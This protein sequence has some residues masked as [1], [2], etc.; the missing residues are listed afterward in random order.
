MK[1]RTLF[2]I[3]AIC[4][5]VPALNISAKDNEALPFIRIVRD[6]AAAAM[7]FAGSASS[8]SI[9]YS[10][11]R[12]ASI[13]PLAND[14]N[15]V[16]AAFSWQNWAPDGTKS[17]NLNFGAG[18]RLLNGKLGLAIG[19]ASQEGEEY[20]VYNSS[21]I[22]SGTY[23]PKDMLVN[24]G[25]GLLITENLS[26]GVNVRY[27][28]QKISDDDSYD[29]FSTDI[30]VTWHVREFNVSAGISSLG[31]SVQDS[32]GNDYNIPTSVTL[33][34]DWQKIFAEQHC[35]KVDADADYFLSGNFTLGLGAQ[36]S[37]KDMIFARAGYH[38]GSSDAVLPSFMTLGAGF[39]FKGVR[40]DFSWLTGNDALK[41][42]LAVGLGFSF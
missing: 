37:W 30:F 21:G 38:I 26:A 12:N 22:Q 11:F 32:E 31:S 6:P 17:T 18:F 20:D 15:I 5:A 39:K 41:N 27:A 1:T 24:F 2:I 35:L 33:A 14:I 29:A 25:A 7:G 23:T 13:I 4:L 10:S 19:G 8:S 9:A 3:L 36:Y 40:L 28:K 34:G 42:T 16:D